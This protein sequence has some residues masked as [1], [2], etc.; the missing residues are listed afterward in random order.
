VTGLTAKESRVLELIPVGH[1][2]AIQARRLAEL[3]GHH[4]RKSRAII[5]HLVVVHGLPIGSSPGPGSAGYFI[6]ADEED[7]SVA[8]RSIK[9]RAIKIFQRARALEKLAQQMFNRQLQLLF[10]D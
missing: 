10:E 8:T 4:E 3:V 2:Q 9:P 7:L 1:E 5:N 6:I